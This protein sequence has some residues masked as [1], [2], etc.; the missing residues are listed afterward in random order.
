MGN[1]H[2]HDEN[3]G[4][5]YKTVP[6]GTFSYLLI[7]ILAVEPR[8][9]LLNLY[10]VL[11]LGTTSVEIDVLEVTWSTKLKIFPKR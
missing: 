9:R 3:L 11:D 7:V 2:R 1:E 4:T 8:L 6:E 10:F 5:V